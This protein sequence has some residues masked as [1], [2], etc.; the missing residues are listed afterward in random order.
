LLSGLAP[1]SLITNE[2]G[3]LDLPF[4]QE[5]FGW[6]SLSP[7]KD[8]KRISSYITKYV[9]K[10]IQ[11]TSIGL[12]KH[13]FYHSLRLN[14][15]ELIREDVTFGGIPEYVWQ[16]DYVGI[17]YC[18]SKADLDKFIE[19]IKANEGH[20]SD[21][22]ISNQPPTIEPQPIDHTVLPTEFD[23]VRGFPDGLPFIFCDPLTGAKLRFT[24]T[25]QG[26]IVNECS[27]LHKGCS[28]VSDVVLYRKLPNGRYIKEDKAAESDPKSG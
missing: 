27:D 21:T 14:G 4:F 8:K 25:E 19:R 6:I 16:N 26:Y 17:Q 15:A 1:E 24:P 23:T 22:G 13:S 20:N 10:A 3:Y 5:R 11:A 18:D 12:C 2:H 7:I 28:G 9:N